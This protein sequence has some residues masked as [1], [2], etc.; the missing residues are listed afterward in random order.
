M[1][2]KKYCFSLIL[3][4]FLMLISVLPASAEVSANLG[5]QRY[6]ARNLSKNESVYSQDIKATE[7][8]NL[9][10]SVNVKNFSS[11]QANEVVLYVYLPVSFPLDSN[12]I[13]IDGIRT[14]GNISNGLFLGN[15]NANSQK[16]IIFK[17]KVN[18][19]LNGYTA[20]QALTAGDNFNTDSQ[21]VSI[22]KNGSVNEAAVTSFSPAPTPVVTPVPT[23]TISAGQNQILGVNVLGKNLTKQDTNWQKTI[24][25]EPGD[26]LQFS[27]MLTADRG[28]VVKNVYLKD[29]LDSF[30]DF[31]SGSVTV[32]N[33]AASNALINSQLFAGEVTVQEAKFI[34][35]QTRVQNASQFGKD[36]IVLS[37]TVQSWAENNPLI[38]DASSVSVTVKQTGEKKST[39]TS[40][41]ISTKKINSGTGNNVALTS[42]NPT[43]PA[44]SK[45]IAK[46][47]QKK[48]FLSG[49]IAFGSFGLLLILILLALVILLATF[50][51]Q[52]KKKN[53]EKT[54]AIS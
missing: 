34:K 28:V 36:P 20:I 24:K 25:A 21:Y 12:S 45:E 30:L 29:T 7:G 23:S 33:S 35:F 40:A 9:E 41:V 1:K 47:A 16:E 38:S 14:G 26:L 5:I 52:E 54:A 17:I 31:V 48:N 10:F 3:A 49:T 46:T 18:G 37:N 13:Y 15:I 8:D 32:N 27:V 44:A 39:I 53:K 51:A 19:Y 2:I 4:S 42:T 22:T 50:L 6:G 43:E 11:N